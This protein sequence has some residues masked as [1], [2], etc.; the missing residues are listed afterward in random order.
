MSTYFE[1]KDYQGTVELSIECGKLFGKIAF[2]QDR[3]TYNA[4]TVPQLEKEFKISV[5]GYLDGCAKLDKS[6]DKPFKGSFN[7]RPGPDL[8]RLAS[9]HAKGSLNAFVI[10]AMRGKLERDSV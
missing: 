4:Y 8:H 1:Y 2:I 6:P 10:D 5:D 9:L 7:V 3:V